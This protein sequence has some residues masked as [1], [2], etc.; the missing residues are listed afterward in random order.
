MLTRVNITINTR[1]LDEDEMYEYFDSMFEAAIED[2]VVKG[3]TVTDLQF[4]DPDDD[5]TLVDGNENPFDT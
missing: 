3:W 4:S 2:E 1:F 5:E